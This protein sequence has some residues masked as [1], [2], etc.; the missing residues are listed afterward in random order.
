MCGYCTEI[1]PI[2]VITKQTEASLLK[3]RALPAI[4]YLQECDDVNF[5]LSETEQLILDSID[6]AE[7]HGFESE[8]YQALLRQD[9]VSSVIGYQTNQS[10]PDDE[11]LFHSDSAL[12]NL[13]RR[14][15]F[16]V[17]DKWDAFATNSALLPACTSLLN[18]YVEWWHKYNTKEADELDLFQAVYPYVFFSPVLLTKYAPRNG[19][20]QR[21]VTTNPAA[22]LFE[23]LEL[24]LQRKASL[25]L[26][27]TLGL[28][29]FL[30]YNRFVLVDKVR[31]ALIYY[32][33]VR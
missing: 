5:A 28:N 19:V 9:V 3:G 23:G 21:L 22:P 32:L 11:R 1:Q 33:L 26:H 15:V 29:A 8:N 24:W 27:E 20:I 4:Y 10:F 31:P 16:L 13:T 12:A 2:Q 25:V 7:N 18:A 14:E 30:P 6:V 17:K